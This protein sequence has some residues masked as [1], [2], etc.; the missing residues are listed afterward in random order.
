[1]K[2]AILSQN[3][4]L[5]STRRLREAA[6]ACGH[7]VDIIDC[8]Q[9]SL[10]LSSPRHLLHTQGSSLEDIDVVIPRIAP[11]ITFLGTTMVRQFETMDIFVANSAAAIDLSRNKL[12]SL[13]VLSHADID[14]P[15]TGFVTDTE[16]I[17]PVIKTLGGMPVV[18]KVLEGTQGIGVILADSEQGAIST[19]EAFIGLRQ[20]VLI[21]E[22]IQEAQGKDLRCFV[23]GDRV[24]AAMERRGAKGEF[25]SN[26]HRG[27]A[28]KKVELTPEEEDISVRA[29]QALGLNI[30]GVDLL[31]SQRGPLVLEVNSSPGLRGIETTSGIDIATQII[32]YLENHGHRRK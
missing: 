9:C 7:R 17:A 10:V 14:I 1:M 28:A 2:I 32:H 29:A 12:R 13:Q 4:E 6:I 19:V 15:M 8:L 18:I 5:Y 22:F 26:L 25:R 24:V 20:N 23:I 3:P 27:G 16:E 30:A 21:Q 31:R 11:T